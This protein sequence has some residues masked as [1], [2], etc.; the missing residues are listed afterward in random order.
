MTGSPTCGC[1]SGSNARTDTTGAGHT[2]CAPRDAQ[3]KLCGSVSEFLWL[4]CRT[5]DGD[6]APL[7]DIES[8]DAVP[9]AALAGAPEA[10]HSGAATPLANVEPERRHRWN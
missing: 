6:A 4:T 9:E 5:V 3:C 2:R 1:R 7:G 8:I 10:L